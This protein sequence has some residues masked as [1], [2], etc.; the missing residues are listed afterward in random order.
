MTQRQAPQPSLGRSDYLL[1]AL[2]FA[3]I[4]AA[5]WML[6]SSVVFAYELPPPINA[7]PADCVPGFVIGVGTLSADS[8]GNGW[9]VGDGLAIFPRPDTPA[10]YRLHSLEG[11]GVEI[12]IR[13]VDAR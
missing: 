9:A 1:L 7:T 13:R 8:T 11:R 12:V 4:A 5:I 6:V 10:E 2:W 3:V